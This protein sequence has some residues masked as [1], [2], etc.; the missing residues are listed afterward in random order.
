MKEA[1]LIRVNL[2]SE[3]FIIPGK[4]TFADSVNERNIDE[5]ENK[6]IIYPNNKDL[7]LWLKENIN[8]PINEYLEIK[9]SSM[10]SMIL[11]WKHILKLM[12]I[13]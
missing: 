5:H 4:S 12:N 10:K 6:G 2:E 13:N 3:P 11:I 8:Y 1:C 9:L 7:I